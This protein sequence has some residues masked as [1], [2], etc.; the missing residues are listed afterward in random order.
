ME[1]DEITIDKAGGVSVCAYDEPDGTCTDIYARNNIVGGATYGGFV[2]IGHKCWDYSS[3]FEG[4]VAHSIKGVLSGIGLYFKNHPT[5]QMQCTQYTGFT[6]YKCYY[7][8]VFSYSDSMKIVLS[9]MTMIDNREGAGAHIL[10]EK[11]QY[12][13]KIESISYYQLK[14]YGEYGSPDCPQ[15]GQGGF[16]HKFKKFGIMAGAGT[17]NNKEFHITALPNLPAQKI[18]SISSWRTRVEYYNTVI[19]GWRTYTE[20]GMQQRAFEINHYSADSTPMQEFYDTTFQNVEDEALGFFFEPPKAWAV[21]K[22]CGSFPCTGPKNTIFSFK[23]NTFSGLR[24]SYAAENFA[25]IP[26]T[27]NFSETVPDC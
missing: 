9:K 22:D 25:M 14:V 7:N 23:R 11:Y 3:R 19:S 20:M 10:N 8:G 1:T 2:T 26:D 15:N 5:E 12:N 24:P 16:C 18:K 17:F 4:N 13:E 21:I 27:P 6:A